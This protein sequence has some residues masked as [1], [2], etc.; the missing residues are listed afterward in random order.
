MVPM[1]AP[2]R[3]RFGGRKCVHL[4][5]S[6]CNVGGLC[7]NLE[8]KAQTHTRDVTVM[9]RIWPDLNLRDPDI[10]VGKHVG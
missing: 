2:M 3:Y 6:G 10:H 1:L 9:S 7:A 5:T 4:G 8:S